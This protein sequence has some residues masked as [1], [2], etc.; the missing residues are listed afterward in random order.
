MNPHQPLKQV[1]RAFPLLAALLVLGG[2]AS[3]PQSRIQSNPEVFA[4]IPAGEQ[5]KAQLGEVAK[6]MGHEAVFIAWG[7][8]SG[9]KSASDGSETWLYAYSSPVYASGPYLGGWGYGRRCGWGG[10]TGPVVVAYDTRIYAKVVF[11][12]GRVTYWERL[13]RG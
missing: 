7:K 5:A 6:G 9:V 2:C 3:T 1:L 8:P 10:W 4:Q 11:N 13:S 12:N